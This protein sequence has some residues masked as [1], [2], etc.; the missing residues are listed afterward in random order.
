[1]RRVVGAVRLVHPFPVGA[2]VLTSALLV[3]VAHRG[4]PGLFF[5][6]RAALVVLLSQISVGSLNDYLDR[7]LDRRVQ[8]EKPIPSGVILPGTALFISLASMVALVPMAATFGTVAFALTVLG[9]AAGLLYDLW[10]KPTPFSWVSYL[11]GFMSLVT[12]IWVIAGHLTSAF[13]L[14]YPAGLLLVLVAHLA[15]SF[16][17]I[18]SDRE[19]NQLGPAA[20][21][22]PSLTFSAIVVGLACAT[23]GALATGLVWRSVPG[24]LLDSFG[25]A[26]TIRIASLRRFAL[27]SR[28]ARLTVFHLAAPAVAVTAVGALL[29]A[30]AHA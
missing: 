5:L 19:T 1:M 21:L 17:D 10:L 16:P 25:V 14:A 30:A 8:P 28:R 2:V 3:V 9:T 4:N 22:G 18:E 12:W 23:I 24:I 6:T 26:L 27:T 11:V 15:Q 13:L 7:D 29:A 20:R